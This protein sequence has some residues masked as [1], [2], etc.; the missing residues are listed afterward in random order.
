VDDTLKS[1]LTRE[2]NLSSHQIEKLPGKHIR[3]RWGKNDK[4]DLEQETTYID[5]PL[6]KIRGLS[7]TFA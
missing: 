2:K 6:L 5:K 1:F 7:V 4:Q 3:H